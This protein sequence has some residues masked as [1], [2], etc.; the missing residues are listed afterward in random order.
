MDRAAK[1]EEI[2]LLEKKA[3]R[4][5]GTKVVRAFPDKGPLRR[6]LYPKHVEFFDKGAEFKERAFVAGNRVGKTYAASY[7]VTLHLTGR[8]PPW[9]KGYRFHRPI[10]AWVAGEDSKTVRESLQ[11]TLMGE[12]GSFGTGLIPANDLVSWTTRSGVPEALDIVKVKHISG[13]TSRLVFKSYDQGRETFQGAK[14]DV[15]WYD[16]EPP[17]DIYTE[18][19]TRTMS[20]DPS[21]ENGLCLCTFTPLKGLSGVV[22]Q[23]LPGG[24]IAKDNTRHVTMVGWDDVPHLSADAKE[25]LASAYLPH[26]RKARTKGVPQL[27]AGA[28]YPV[29]ENDLIIPPIQFPIWYKHVFALDVGWNRTAALWGAIDPETD[30]LYLYSEHYQG[31]APPVVH[32]EGIKGRGSWI[33]GVIDPAARGRSQ[34]DGEDLYRQYV[35]TGLKLSLADNAVE[36]G[37]YNV[38]TRMTSGRL[39]IFSTLLNLLGEF[40]IYRRDEKGKIV[41]ENDH[42]MD[43][44]RYLCMTGIKVAAHKPYDMLNIGRKQLHQ[45]EYNPYESI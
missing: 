28:I 16:E 44:L 42:L 10:T 31:E 19:L 39:K 33:P 24:R 32:A 20:T 1:I 38:W 2:T 25:K 4:Y 15:M 9:W 23:Y 26:E 17:T 6:E 27:G 14:I 7:E 22:L 35:A 11:I 43:C 21:E 34:K 3:Q 30:I 45:T 29:D 12:T 13:G 36:S 8:Y 41:K 37:I 40:R 18:G 5:E